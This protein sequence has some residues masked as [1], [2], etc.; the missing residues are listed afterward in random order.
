MIRPQENTKKRSFVSPVTNTPHRPNRDQRPTVVYCLWLTKGVTFSHSSMSFR[1]SKKKKKRTTPAKKPSSPLCR[2]SP[3][4]DWVAGARPLSGYHDTHISSF[5]NTL[6]FEEK[7][8]IRIS[9]GPSAGAPLTSVSVKN[10]IGFCKS[11]RTHSTTVGA[12][13][14]AAV[15]CS[16]SRD[17]PD[18]NNKTRPKIIFPR[19]SC[20]RFGF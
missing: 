5:S 19:K 15:S 6:P 18:L 4:P 1:P 16:P 17:S 11:T 12:K 2:V 10:E 7:V 20:D 9:R 3:S 13:G 14:D 8:E